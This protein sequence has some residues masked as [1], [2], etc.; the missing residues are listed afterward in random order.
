MEIHYREGRRAPKG[1]PEKEMDKKLKIG[2]NTFDGRVM[3]DDAEYAQ[4]I[5]ECGGIDWVWCHVDARRDLD[6]AGNIEYAGQVANKLKA[7]GHEFVANFEFQ[8][9]AVEHVDTDGHDYANCPDGCHRLNLPDGFVRALAKAGNLIGVAYDEFEHTIINRNLSVFIGTKL[10]K[11]LPVFPNLKTKDPVEQGR[12]LGRQV[13]EFVDGFKANGAGKFAGEHVFP[14]LFHLFA[15]NGVIPNFK[16]QKESSSNVQFAVAAGA[17][18]QY[19]KELWNCVDMW[20][21]MTFPGHSVKEMYHNLVFAWLMGV[22]RVYVEASNAF[23]D[24]KGDKKELNELGKTYCS[25]VKEYRGRDRQYDIQDFK[26]EVGIVR[27]DTGYWGQGHS[28]FVWRNMLYGN[29][30]LKGTKQSKEWVRAMYL[31][32][33]REISPNSLTQSRFE[34]RSLCRHRSFV[35]MNNAAVFDDEVKKETL[36]PLKL[37]FLCGEHISDET[38]EAVRALAKENGL[39]VVS[40]RR[41]APNEVLHAAGAGFADLPYG[42]G[43]W[44]ITNSFRSRR[45]EKRISPFLGEKGEMRFVLGDEEIRLKIDKDGES[46]VRC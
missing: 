29:P 43:R 36:E 16:S 23:F 1:A 6:T 28:L 9:F 45:L 32:T 46:F 15:K 30:M 24:K 20:N 10:K 39:C 7:D 8:N 25:Y 38:L 5:Q 44:I 11:D 4:L 13:R 42:E 35:S 12:A 31:I 33:H 3:A 40:T 18:L 19:G 26:P 22:N 34:L 21:V 17:A 27:L 41:F 14:V 2:F 37:C